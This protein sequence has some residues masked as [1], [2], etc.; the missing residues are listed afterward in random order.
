MERGTIIPR[1]AAHRP[2][3]HAKAAVHRNRAIKSI[4]CLVSVAGV[5][6]SERSRTTQSPAKQQHVATPGA[7]FTWKRSSSLLP[8]PAGAG[9]YL[10]C[11]QW[12]F[13][14]LT[15]R[16]CFGSSVGSSGTI[17][18]H[19]PAPFLF[20]RASVSLENFCSFTFEVSVQGAPFR[21]CLRP[22]GQNIT[23]HV[24]PSPPQLAKTNCSP[25]PL[26]H[27]GS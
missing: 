18:L 26:A 13:D 3:C 16:S 15:C 17:S 14:A 11:E 7:G 23:R 12:Q 1:L 21:P 5:T 8:S 25:V 2:A 22:E 6:C 27:A 10:G 24:F 20:P 4:N 9:V 19:E